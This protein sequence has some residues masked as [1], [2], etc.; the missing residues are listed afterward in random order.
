MSI[1]NFQSLICVSLLPIRGLPPLFFYV[2]VESPLAA[3]S[4]N[5]LLIDGAVLL[6]SRWLVPIVRDKADVIPQN[7]YSSRQTKVES[8]GN[9]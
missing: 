3:P 9:V 6:D 4:T 1:I 8:D 5:L 2:F 7:S